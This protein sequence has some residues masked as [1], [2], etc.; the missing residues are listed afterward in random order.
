M[1]G[2][3]LARLAAIAALV[4][5]GGV[6]NA[7]AQAPIERVIDNTGNKLVLIPAGEFLMGAAETDAAADE[8]EKPQR[9]IRIGK[10]FY[11]GAFEVTVGQF[12]KFVADTGYQTQ[13]EKTGGGAVVDF[14]TGKVVVKPELNWKNPGFPQTEEHPVVQV[15]WNDAVA[16]CRWLADREGATYRLPTEAEWE[17]ACRAGTTTRFYSGDDEQG[18]RQVA[19]IADGALNDHRA[20][21]WASSWDDGYAFSAP[22][23]K[24]Q[25]NAFGL[26]DM[27]GNVWEWCSDWYSGKTYK[28]GEAT[29]PKGPSTG[30]V[31]VVR[32]GAWY[33]RPQ[34]N[35][36]TF[37]YRARPD[38]RD[39]LTGF[40]VVRETEP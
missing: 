17:Y 32:G 15:S 38:L 33:Y 18:L 16:Y 36:A 31:R 8:D 1:S 5:L 39:F 22:V 35:R 10:P 37:R 3:C 2:N 13:A 23:G 29:D 4:W 6:A 21:R 11:L 28:N 19:N 30:T 27:H 12:G 24:F 9:R 25:P 20:I 14:N 26:H 34:D 40:R 7:R